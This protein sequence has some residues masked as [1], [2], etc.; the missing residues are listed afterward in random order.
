MPN[1]TIYVSDEDLPLYKQ[2]QELAG[3]SLSAA[4]TDAL[5]RYVDVQDTKEAGYDDITVR[6]GIG[7]GRKQRFSGVLIGEWGRSTNDQEEAFRVYRT[8]KG[9]F[10]V[11]TERSE[12]W[13]ASGPNAQKWSTGWRGWIGDW[14]SD[15]SWGF[16]PAEAILQ[17]AAT[18]AELG[19]LLPPE[20]YEIVARNADKP[21]VENLD[22]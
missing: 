17:V 6:V 22:I 7:A 14:S 11:H 16:T 21:V 19:E 15:Q 4:I 2:A 18:L 12:R 3:G 10:V 1:K 20:L 13:T 8:R 5:R 9:Q